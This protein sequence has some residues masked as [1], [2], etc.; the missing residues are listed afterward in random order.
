MPYRAS[1]ALLDAGAPPPFFL[2][3]LERLLR[4]VV[5]DLALFRLRGRR[6]RLLRLELAVVQLPV[7]GERLRADDEGGVDRAHVEVGLV[8]L[9]LVQSLEDERHGRLG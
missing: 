1:T 7:A 9:G 4:L 6:G 8:V 3:I 5:V 2:V